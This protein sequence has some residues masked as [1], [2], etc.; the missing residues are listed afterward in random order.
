MHGESNNERL[1]SGGAEA[2]PT[3]QLAPQDHRG[4]PEFETAAFLA[5]IVESSND[6]IISKDLNGIIT[7]WNQGAEHI[8]WAASVKPRTKWSLPR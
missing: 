8:Y 3:D 5:A 4:H 7:S 1:L 6:A 2:G